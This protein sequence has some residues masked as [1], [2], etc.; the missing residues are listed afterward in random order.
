M[1]DMAVGVLVH[2]VAVPDFTLRV[3]HIHLAMFEYADPEPSDS[4]VCMWSG[5]S[6]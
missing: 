5:G 6:M 4:T 3:G 1:P 2:P